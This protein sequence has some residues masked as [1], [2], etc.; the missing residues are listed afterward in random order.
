MNTNQ[1]LFNS[2][3]S[4]SNPFNMGGNLNTTTQDLENSLIQS[5]ARLEALKAK[6][7]QLQTV[8]Q[9]TVFTDIASEFEGLSAD[10]SA[11][12]VNSK[13]Y[14]TLNAKYQNEF[15]QFLI[16]KFSGEYMQTSNIKTLEE[17]LFTIRQKK[18][19]YKQKFA[20]DI[21]EIRDQ[22]KSL[23][24]KNNQLAENNQLLQEQLKNIQERF[25]KDR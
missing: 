9:N 4:T 15:S 19:Q 20:E 1:T 5:Y 8:P 25:L 12:I 16:T 21:N 17:M 14:Q 10:E 2:G 23:V 11:F 13:E 7:N 24:E 6:Q 22:N 3:F 18:E